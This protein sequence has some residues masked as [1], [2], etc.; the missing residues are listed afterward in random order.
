[1]TR[2]NAM[3]AIVFPGSARRSCPTAWHY[4]L[5]SIAW[6]EGN[7]RKTNDIQFVNVAGAALGHPVSRT[8]CGYWQRAVQAGGGSSSSLS[9]G[10]CAVRF[11]MTSS[12]FSI[13]KRS[14]ITSLSYPYLISCDT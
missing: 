1:M 13:R 4:S 14:A 12:T 7:R 11:S 10:N 5:A 3:A 8:W 9:R 2:H 6:R